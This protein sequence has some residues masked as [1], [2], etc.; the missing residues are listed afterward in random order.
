[1]E[2]LFTFTY[3]FMHHSY[4]K[5]YSE[6]WLLETISFILMDGKESVLERCDFPPNELIHFEWKSSEKTSGPPLP[7][8]ILIT[9]ISQ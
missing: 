6:T 1:M 5:R 7:N 2:F 9:K 8:L 4:D 3:L